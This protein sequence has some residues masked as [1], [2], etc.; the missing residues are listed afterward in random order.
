MNLDAPLQDFIAHH[1]RLF[2]LTGAGVSTHS[3]LPDYRDAEGNWKRSPPVTYQAFMNDLPTRRRYWARSLI[4]WRH[5]GQVQPNGAHRAL[6]RLENR[7]KVE[8]LVTQNVDR[9][10]QKAGSRNVID[11]HGRIDMVRC[12][13]CAL[14]M[15]R[16]SFQLLLEAHN[17]RWAVLEASAA[18]DGDADLDGVAFEDFVIPPCPRC[19]GIIKPDV[20]FFGESV[21][22]ERVDTA[23]AHLEKADAVLVVGTSL[24]VRSGFRFVEAAVKAGKPVGAVNLGRTRA[25]EWLAFKVARATDEALAFLL[26]E[27][28]A[29]TS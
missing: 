19:G 9:L 23:F 11:L 20:V 14:E 1:D 7:G 27:A 6:A 16:Q 25:D 17:P 12:M 24:M 3:G 5:I 28:T 18:P 13:S 21:P 2:V 29:G 8:V 26:P 22:K 4:G 15:D 10:H